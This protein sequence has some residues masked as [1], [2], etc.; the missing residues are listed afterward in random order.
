MNAAVDQERERQRDN[1]KSVKK[2]TNS[3]NSRNLSNYKYWFSPLTSIIFYSSSPRR[4]YKD[5]YRCRT[6]PFRP[7]EAGSLSLACLILSCK[8]RKRRKKKRCSEDRYTVPEIG[9]NFTRS[10][11]I[12]DFWRE[13]ERLAE[14]G[15]F[16]FGWYKLFRDFF[17][18]WERF[19][20]YL[21]LGIFKGHW[22]VVVKVGTRKKVM[23]FLKISKNTY[24]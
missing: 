19:E 3:R 11:I 24:L 9:N 15:L 6:T 2:Q 16:G 18:I 21:I 7:R 20:N 22:S 8:K 1:S 17:R 10:P 14:S 23:C 13:R 12:Q 5:Y 4:P